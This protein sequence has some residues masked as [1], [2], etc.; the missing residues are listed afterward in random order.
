MDP[1]ILVT[2]IVAF[3]QALLP[4]ISAASTVAKIIGYL[5]EL[6]PIV[7]KVAQDVLPEIK[8]IIAALQS[9]SATTP[10]QLTQLAALDAQVDAAFDAAATAA[11]ADDATS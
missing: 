7:V 9:N 6:I 4:E 5:V 10:D 1:A 2:G 11:E 3:L 8:N